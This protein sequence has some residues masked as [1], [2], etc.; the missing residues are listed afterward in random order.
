MDSEKSFVK[1]AALLAFSGMVVKGLSAI[2][3]IP[4]TAM[5]GAEVMGRYTAVFNV[6][7]PF[8]SL[9]VRGI[10]RRCPGF[11]PAGKPVGK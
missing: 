4:I 10:T 9:G 3:R 1:G 5:V 7:M 8:F 2:Y 11:A 6:F